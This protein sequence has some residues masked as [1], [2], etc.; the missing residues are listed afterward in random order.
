MSFDNFLT[1]TARS[2]NQPGEVLKEKLG[3]APRCRSENDIW[4]LIENNNQ[5]VG[6]VWF[7]IIPKEKSA[8]G[9]DIYLE[10]EY[11]SKGIGR[12]VMKKCQE[13]LIGRGIE[14]V[15]ICVFEHNEISRRLYES[16]GFT[17]ESFNDQRRQFSLV[18]SLQ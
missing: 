15:K 4:L 17:V 12:Y 10:P 1:E 2:S 18:M 8:F 11:R 3:G 6:F 14:S 16:F 5:R 13:E 7:Q 9:W